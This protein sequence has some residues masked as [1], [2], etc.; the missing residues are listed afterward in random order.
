MIAL[1]Y[2][3]PVFVDI[4]PRTYIMDPKLIEVAITDKTLAINAG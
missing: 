4:D 1:L 2:S 3:N